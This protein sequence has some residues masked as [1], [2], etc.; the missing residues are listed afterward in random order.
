MQE[1]FFSGL[2]PV[3]CDAVNK[4]DKTK[5]LEKTLHSSDFHASQKR[6]LDIRTP[7]A[8]PDDYSKYQFLFD[9]TG[10][11]DTTEDCYKDCVNAFE[12]ISA[13]PCK[14]C[15]EPAFFVT[16]FLGGLA[17]MAYAASVDVGCG[18]YSYTI[19]SA[20]RQCGIS[21]SFLE[22][23]G[24]SMVPWNVDYA[25]QAI[26]EFCTD[27]QDKFLVDPATP[28][29]PPPSTDFTRGRGSYP[30][31]IYRYGDN[32]TH[33]TSIFVQSTPNA[34]GCSN[35]EK[36]LII[37]Y[38]DRCTKLLTQVLEDPGPCKLYNVL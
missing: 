9:W 25:K 6:L 16:N 38:S 28:Q 20:T 14:C 11:T 26:D 17:G 7:P 24:T 33:I 19:E 34:K 18:K 5:P 1:N 36:F 29:P 4:N 22:G 21:P 32:R 2:Y 31:Q 37:D 3:F 30:S 27:T 23:T 10:V 35:S 12:Y 13:S 8:N 15:G